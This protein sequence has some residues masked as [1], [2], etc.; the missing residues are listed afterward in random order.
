MGTL[1]LR[2]RWSWRD[3]RARWLQVAAIALVIGIGSGVYSG[4]SSTTEWRQASYDASYRELV[5]WDLHVG[6]AEGS[7]VPV[8]EL[9]GAVDDLDVIEAV[10]ARLV[11]P[12]QVDAS[13]AD[14][15]VLVPGQVIGVPVAD[16]GP[17]IARIHATEGRAL[18]AGDEGRDV[19]AVD[20][21]F[22]EH[23][24]L[25]PG[26]EIR[27]LDGSPLRHVGRVLSPEH[28]MI[29]PPQG[30]VFGESGYAVLW[31]PIETVGRLTGMDG[32]A[33]DLVITYR[34]G[35][36]PEAGQA[37]VEEALATAL[38]G[39]GAAT[40]R[41]DQDRVLRMLYDDIDGDQR[42][43]DVF[44]LLILFG[45]AFA[46]FN[47]TGRIIE[48]QRR[49]I[50]I[51][52][53]MGVPTA[54][55]AA[56]PLLV[57]VQVALLG[58]AF[59]V[60]VGFAIQAALARVLASVFPMPIW[61][62]DFQVGVFARGASLG[63]V[64]PV[65]ATIGPIVRAVRVPP[66]DAISTTH[67][68]TGG[69]GLAP[70]LRRIRIPGSSLAQLPFRNVLRAP[71]RS[72]L[73]ALGIGAAIA[74]LVGVLGMMDSYLTTLDRGRE[75]ILGDTPDRVTID[76]DPAPIGSEAVQAVLTDPV[77]GVA[78]PT[79][80]LGGVLDP[81][82]EGVEVF[83]SA[84]DLGSDLWRP[85][86]IDGSVASDG[87]G[88]VL[89]QKAVEDLGLAVGDGVVLRHPVREGLGFRL[90]DTELPVIAVHP[91]PFRFT[92]YLDIVHADLFDLA[93]VAN[94]VSAVPASGSSVTDVQRA[95]FGRP[96]VVSVQPLAAQ[97]EAIEDRLEDFLAIFDILQVVV[98]AMALLIAFNST[99]INVDE[100]RRENATM[101]AFGVPVRSALRS[102][103]TESLLTGVLG[104][105]VGIGV[106]RALVTW[107]TQGLMADTIP[108]LGIVPEVAAGTL[109]TAVVLGVVAVALA[110]LL[111]VR[112]LRRMDI[113]STLRV[114][115]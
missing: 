12:T 18:E 83:L 84:V 14:T 104:I 37:A 16:G 43:N 75:E 21:H 53:A 114:V 41:Q 89:A 58:V 54:Q 107:M 59:G 29:I 98:L 68:A 31:A 63:L 100:R 79:L 20:E 82:G 49:E 94:A 108:E 76:L 77:L 13:T 87:P 4:L 5:M 40:T 93:G 48:A 33:N 55:L 35:V 113:P 36:T 22:A 73:T 26:G 19:V 62:T 28:F 92:A 2:L 69:G 8:E 6:L 42:F 25:D 110:P 96:G 91:N 86:V 90:V 46:A 50:G 11:L 9:L 65:V 27:A 66:V 106:G 64:L 88:L 109:V 52:M 15:T 61:I 99:S 32:Q 56:R 115:E 111:T 60:G 44:A 30:T 39:V 80:V 51:G 24:G 10:E 45:A 72:L 102:N 103:V 95:L 105:A 3:L 34:E 112:K 23:F 38:P 67:R 101:F 7:A 71:R 81:G 74:T 97:A 17:G 1:L 70:L 57:G 85:T 78:E 47:L